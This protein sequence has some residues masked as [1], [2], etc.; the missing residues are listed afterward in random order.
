LS[1]KPVHYWISCQPTELADFS[2]YITSTLQAIAASKTL[3][4]AGLADANNWHFIA[5]HDRQ[6]QISVMWLGLASILISE[7][8]INCLCEH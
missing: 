7:H 8:G 3:S 5:M 2:N 4:T 6:M 1:A